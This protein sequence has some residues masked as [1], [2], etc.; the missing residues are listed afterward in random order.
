MEACINS[1]LIHGI[2]NIFARGF[3]PLLRLYE[4]DGATR[5]L[6]PLLHNSTLPFLFHILRDLILILHAPEN[7]SYAEYDDY[8]C[9]DADE[10][11]P[12]Q[13]SLVHLYQNRKN[14][15]LANIVRNC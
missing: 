7:H 6:A 13:I 1:S 5:A 14:Y 4:Q 11:H 8:C 12:G 3:I 9:A 15:R 2:E 10:I